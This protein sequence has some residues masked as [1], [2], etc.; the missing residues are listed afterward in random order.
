M[1][2]SSTISTAATISQS[3]RWGRLLGRWGLSF[4]GYPLGGGVA[5]VV[6]GHVDGTPTALA[7]GLI[8]GI[9][10]GAVQAWALRADRALARAW[11]IASALGLM[12]GLG[13][14]A[15]A[16][17]FDTDLGDLALQGAVSGA[18]LG[19]AQAVVLL[20]RTGPLALAWPAY[21]AVVWAI[22]WA[23]TT[24]SGIGVDAQ[25]TVFGSS[26][27]LVATAL[28]TVLPAVLRNPRH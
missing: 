4:L 5:F 2:S 6:V 9:V 23:V 22:G 21:L 8:T 20:R 16:V 25:F 11:V 10:L 3:P 18:V 15:T 7:G 13:I 28:T 19:L 27:A 12:V 17:G 14:G 1:S 24:V 26:G